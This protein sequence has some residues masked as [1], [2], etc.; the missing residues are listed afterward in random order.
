MGGGGLNKARWGRDGGL[1]EGEPLSRQQRGSPSP[2]KLFPL[3]GI[4]RGR[5]F[6][7]DAFEDGADGGGL[8]AHGV[9]V[10]G[11]GVHGF[12]DAF[13]GVL[14]FLDVAVD[15]VGHGGLLRGGF[16][17]DLHT[18]ADVGDERLDDGHGLAGLLGMHGQRPLVHYD[19]L[20]LE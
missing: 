16:G 19:Y 4:G 10:L 8:A 18:G 9:Y 3:V 7:L 6:L 5:F 11:G 15:G 1:G 13:S 14:D 12:G 20:Y 17:N 2:K